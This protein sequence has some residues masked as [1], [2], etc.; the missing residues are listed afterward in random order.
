MRKN[1]LKLHIILR[2]IK[3]GD[4]FHVPWVVLEVVLAVAFESERHSKANFIEVDWI[5]YIELPILQIRRNV[6]V[7]FRLEMN[8]LDERIQHYDCNEY[9]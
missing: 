5:I 4:P 9:H 7:M 6:W 8:E 1:T 2:A 3:A